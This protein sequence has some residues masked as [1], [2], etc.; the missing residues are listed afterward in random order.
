MNDELLLLTLGLQLGEDLEGK[1]LEY[2]LDKASRK[3][4]ELNGVLN[5]VNTQT[6]RIEVALNKV[7]EQTQQ[8]T[9]LVGDLREEAS[10]NRQYIEV[11]ERSLLD[12][13]KERDGYQNQRD[14]YGPLFLKDL[15]QTLGIPDAS[16]LDAIMNRLNKLIGSY[17]EMFARLLEQKEIR[18]RQNGE[19]YWTATGELLPISEKI[20]KEEGLRP[21]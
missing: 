11:L 1:T 10:E 21:T 3:I 15:C 5:T 14:E 2:V 13:E 4:T 19:I 17:G 7:M 16:S 6:Q 18:V 20:V 8:T 9:E 12:A